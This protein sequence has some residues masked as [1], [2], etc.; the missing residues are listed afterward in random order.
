MIL[1][2]DELTK[3]FHEKAFLAATRRR[4]SN[5][6]TQ[7]CFKNIREKTYKFLLW[8]FLGNLVDPEYENLFG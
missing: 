8:K 7:N 6:V 1:F 2:A 3:K 4:R 5:I